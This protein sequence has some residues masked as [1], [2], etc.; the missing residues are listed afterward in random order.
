MKILRIIS[1]IIIGLVFIFSGVVKAIDPTGTVYKFQDYFT[2]FNISFL[3]ELSLF[4]AILL[5]SAEVVAGISVLLN[6]RQKTG[7]WIVIIMMLIFTPL[8]FVLALTNPVSDCGCFGD[9]IHLTNWQTFFK[10]IIILLP[11]LFL[12]ITRNNDTS[13]MSYN[14]EWI[15]IS[16]F[17][18]IFLCFI[19]YNLRYL[20]VIDFLPYKTGTYIPDKMIIPEGK[21]VDRYETTFIYEKDGRLKEFTLDNYPA[22]DTTWKF[23]EQKSV[24]VEKGFIPPI[25]DFTITTIHNED[26]TDQV[27]SSQKPVILMIARKLEE[28]DQDLLNAGFELG[29]YCLNNMIDFHILTASGTDEVMKYNNGLTFCF[30]DEIT[31]KTMIRSNPGY[32]ALEEGTIT[33]KWSWANLPENEFFSEMFYAQ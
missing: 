27:L 30:T 19:A 10:N 16:V 7:I 18:I 8:T 22:N 5:C 24:L 15:T 2:A 4:F 25:H 6:I 23:V 32:M 20:P 26:I 12:F 9:A 29:F 28:T 11:A 33:G 14:G 1:R 17:M 31:L 3:N 13:Y 21:P